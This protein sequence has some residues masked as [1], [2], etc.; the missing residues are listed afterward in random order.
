MLKPIERIVV[1]VNPGVVRRFR[2][3]QRMLF[4]NMSTSRKSQE[5]TQFSCQP[6]LSGTLSGISRA[7]SPL[8]GSGIS[9]PETGTLA[10]AQIRVPMRAVLPLAREAK[11]E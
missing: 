1:K 8:F 5:D 10:S 7:P 11:P 4:S 3:A 2:H 6:S 9:R